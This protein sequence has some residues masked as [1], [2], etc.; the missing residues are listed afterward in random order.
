[1]TNFGVEQVRKIS[2]DS[3]MLNEPSTGQYLQGNNRYII[4]LELTDNSVPVNIPTGAEIIL[5]CRL[6]KEGSTIYRM[7]STHD[8]FASIVSFTPDTNIVKVTKWADLVRDHG[9]VLI[10]VTIAGISTYAGMIKVDKNQMQGG[11]EVISKATPRD[12]LLKADLSNINQESLKNLLKTMDFAQNDLADVKLMK[13]SE[14]VAA[15]DVGKELK[16]N[17]NA[18]NMYDSPTAF[19]NRLK[20]SAAFIALSKGIHDTT[21]GM[22]PEEIK[23]LFY[24]NRYEEIEAVDLTKEPFTD[25]KVLLLVYQFTISNQVITQRLPPVARGQIIM[26]EIIRSPGVT[27]GKLVFQPSPGDLLDGANTPVEVLDTGYDG[28]WLPISNGGSYGW[29]GHERTQEYALTVSDEKDTAILGVKALNFKGASLEDS[30]GGR[31][32]V[33][34]DAPE[35]KLPFVDGNLKQDFE[36]TKVQSLDGSIRIANLGGVADLSTKSDISQEGIMATLGS[37]EI[38]NSKYDKESFWFEDIKHKGGTYVYANLQNKS[39]IVQEIDQKDPNLTGGTLFLLGLSYVPSKFDSGTI[40]QEGYFRVEFVNQ[41]GDLLYD[42]DGNPMATEV[43]YKSGQ[44]ERKQLYLGLIRAKAYTE[45]KP[46]FTTNFANEEL[47]TMGADTAIVIQPI[48]DEVSSGIAL[49][50]F[51]AYTGYSISLNKRYYGTNSMNLARDLIFDEPITETDPQTMYFGNNVW[52]DNRSKISRGIQNYALVVSDVGG[53]EM[54]VFSLFKRYNQYDTLILQQERASAKVTVK[55]EDK[56]NAFRVKLL[57]YIGDKTDDIPM[58]NLLRFDNTA[59]VFESGWVSVDDLFISEDV[60]DGIHTAKKGFVLPSDGKELAFVMYA[61]GG[62][63]PLDLKLQDFEIDITPAFTR[64]IITNNSH[65]DEELLYSQ[66]GYYKA[67]TNCPRGSYSYRYTVGDTDTKIPAGVV[68]G[69]DSD[70]VNNNA[71]KDAGSTDP[72]KVQGDLLFKVDGKVNFEYGAQIYNETD[73][74]NNIEFW[75]VKVNE[76]GSFTEVPNSRYATTIEAKRATPKMIVSNS[77]NFEVKENESYRIFAKSN[78]KDGFY[79]LCTPNGSPLFYSS[80]VYNKL[81]PIDQ[82]IIDLIN[83]K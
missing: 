28:F 41:N 47:F 5:R 71:W 67:T 48:T 23:S 62:G 36:A 7:D 25:P 1:M 21:K 80:I 9:T 11:Q 39:F 45:I 16:S 30:G 69:S 34:P 78:V 17:T 24:T 66:K 2:L 37:D 54:P 12:D 35:S 22:T 43:H 42:I 68:K 65:I 53:L 72:Y 32:E 52:F 13:L 8:D 51:M 81:E 38:Y 10:T 18:I 15:T 79:L 27:G 44:K 75:V 64:V 82:R 73:T 58:P 33:I 4:D 56:K 6:Q 29:Y 31:V 57:K 19:N 59:P 76:D 20:Q 83:K 60:V 26:V 61:V 40:T 55:I 70:I 77:F 63:Q 74:L 46:R 14:K 49:L 50:N 3:S